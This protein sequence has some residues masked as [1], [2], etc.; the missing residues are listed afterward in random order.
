[1]SYTSGGL[2]LATVSLMYFYAVT[3]CCVQFILGKAAAV[4][5]FWRQTRVAELLS[6]VHDGPIM[7]RLT[8]KLN[9]ARDLLKKATAP[10]VA[11]SGN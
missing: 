1:M 6:L 2:K 5:D 9:T 3:R 4:G 10:V 7:G 8:D 11:T